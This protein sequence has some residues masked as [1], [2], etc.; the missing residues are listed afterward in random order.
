MTMDGLQSDRPDGTQRDSMT[1]GW[2]KSWLHIRLFVEFRDSPL[3]PR[4]ATR[5][6]VITAAIGAANERFHLPKSL[7]IPSS[8]V[9]PALALSRGSLNATIVHHL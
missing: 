6:M 4:Q 1:N 9:R 7:R 3:Q 5:L 8:R 2:H